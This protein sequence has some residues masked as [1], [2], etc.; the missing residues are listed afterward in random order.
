[1]MEW[2]KFSYCSEK[3]CEEAVEYGNR[4]VERVHQIVK[5]L[6]KNGCPGREHLVVG[7]TYKRE[8]FLCLARGFSLFCYIQTTRETVLVLKEY[9]G[10]IYLGFNGENEFDQTS[11]LASYQKN[12]Q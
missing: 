2:L 7:R 8:I 5:W 9:K 12:W 10:S 3:T 1:M 4:M 6:K 11:S